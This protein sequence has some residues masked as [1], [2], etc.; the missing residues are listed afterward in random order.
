[1]AGAAL[2]VAQYVGGKATRDALFL[3][4]LHF[5]ALPAVLI[6]TAAG[7]ITLVALN[8]RAARRIA[9]ATLVPASFVASGV[10]FL[11]EW[12]L[13]S[14]APSV[15]A[16]AVYLHISS[17]TPLLASGFWL[18]SSERFDPRTA[19]QR[20]GHVAAAGTLGGLAGAV[21][22]ERVGA[23]VGA[24]A[25]L[26]V[27]AAL[28][29][30]GALIVRSLAAEDDGAVPVS[31]PAAA[32]ARGASPSPYFR[33]L[34][35]IVLL[36]SAAAALIDYLF[37]ATAVGTFGRGDNLLRFFAI[38]YGATSIVTFVV[39]AT[40]SRAVLERHGL[41]FMTASPS[42]ALIAGSIGNLIAPGFGAVM[43]MR[44]SEAVFRGS[45]FRAGYELFYTPI[46]E[47]DKRTAK[48]IIDV[49]FDRLGDGVG[50]GLVR[51]VLL[52][53]PAVQSTVILW[54]AILCSIAAIVAASRLNR[55]YISTLE[56]NLLN[57]AGGIDLSDLSVNATRTVFAVPGAAPEA[58][59]LNQRAQEKTVRPATVGFDADMRDI[60]SLRS[61]DRDRILDVLSRETGLTSALL[62]HAIPLL[63][64]DRVA[65]HAVSALRKVAE[66]HVGELADAL[67][68]PNQDFAVRR[69]LA[70]VFSVCVSQRAADSLM[71]GLDDPRFDVRYQS[72][73]SL[74]A[75]VD[76]NP[77]VTVERER[78][79]AVV[80]R[81]V[82]VGRPVWESRRLL[83]ADGP[84]TPSALD[85]FVRDRA[86]QSLAH[87]FTLLSLVL[88][89]EPLHIAFR[90]LQSEDG[91]LKGTALEYLD[92]VLPEPIR[93]RIWPFL[94]PAT[95]VPPGRPNQEAIAD[96]LRSN[97]SVWVN[98]AELGKR[99]LGA[100]ARA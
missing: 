41:G 30:A 69:R 24:P 28:Q 3:T 47:A 92:G 38:Y 36:G 21:L 26:P 42:Y 45:L 2:V 86:S 99:T 22:A 80:L 91:Q 70:R 83:D 10:L 59:G 90:S 96:L 48:S 62:P 9:P 74:A 40:S 27:L 49:V 46:A 7:S 100:G 37:K 76:K 93:E 11:A 79:L 60:A 97:Q 17:A 54:L 78:I 95:A 20:F 63:A 5:T 84:D 53:A 50:G 75:I 35:A 4:S 87:V 51:L 67:V 6:A 12:L 65:E 52:F 56:N 68:D 66:E 25:M 34:A 88:P 81:E 98:V 29:F 14:T 55:G 31:E 58:T 64:W 82:T 18:I 16:V 39:Q 71:L 13:R 43:A 15:V 57:R 73:R 85:M 77:R 94:E 44:A 1:M 23:L 89:R 61:R 8:V 32:P 33:H 72:A 19:K